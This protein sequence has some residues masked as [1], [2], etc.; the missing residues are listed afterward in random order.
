MKLSQSQ[1]AATKFMINYFCLIEKYN[2]AFVL[3][4][5]NGVTH[6]KNVAI[7]T[8]TGVVPKDADEA[9]TLVGYSGEAGYLRTLD[10]IRQIERQGHPLLKFAVWR[11][12]VERLVSCYKHFCLEG[13]YREYFCF[14]N[15]Y[16]DN[17]FDRFMEFVRF[18]LGKGD[19]FYQDEHIR[20]QS[21]CYRPEDVDCIVP[22]RK[23]NQFLLDHN[24][25]LPE[26]A[27]NATHVDF[28]LTDPRYIE[29]IKELYKA[30]YELVP[31]Y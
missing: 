11:D 1:K 9:H 19:P 17:S 23:L 13:E 12:P 7:Y 4:S 18:E 29:E 31:T 14:L 3:I 2:M 16:Q 28:K 22:I 15:L 24:V 27:A 5:K 20:R 25:P 21:D 26:I 6:L 30:D 10:E 8:R